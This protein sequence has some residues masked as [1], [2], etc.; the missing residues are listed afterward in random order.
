MF[1]SPDAEL[2]PRLRDQARER[3]R[4]EI[5]DGSLAPG[6]VLDDEQL[7]ERLRCSRTPVREALSDLAHL[8]LVE[9][10]P[11][12]YTRVVVPRFEELLPTL[13]ALGLL[14]GGVVRTAVPGMDDRA[15]SVL[16]RR[17]GL[18]LDCMGDPLWTTSQGDA[19]SPIYRSLIAACENPVLAAVLESATDG[20]TYRLRHDAVRSALPWEQI[21][22]GLVALRIAIDCRDGR[23]AERAT[24]TIHQLPDPDRKER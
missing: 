1:A 20:L 5:M 21:R 22:N 14:F 8:G 4:A 18:L 13:Q 12:R 2:R 17:L 15:R 10:R 19:L 24:W 6:T 16:F 7:A 11:N 9:L 3:L 23:L